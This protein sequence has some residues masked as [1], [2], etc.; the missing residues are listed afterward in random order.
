VNAANYGTGMWDDRDKKT[1]ARDGFTVHAPLA[2][3]TKA[4]IIQL[5][6]KLK[7]DLS[8][9]HSCYDPD[10]RGTACGRCDSCSIRRRGFAEAGIPDPTR[11]Q[12]VP[13]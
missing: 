2:A 8:I 3:L 1:L 5:G 13:S 4:Q 11:Y 12:S 10:A 9:T 7:V 6:A